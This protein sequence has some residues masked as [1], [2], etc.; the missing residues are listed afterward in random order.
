MEEDEKTRRENEKDSHDSFS[1]SFVTDAHNERENNAMIDND[2]DVHHDS[3][4]RAVSDVIALGTV[5]R[6]GCEKMVKDD[7]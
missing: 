4:V 6:S 1:I 7:S 2:V 5:F 3:S